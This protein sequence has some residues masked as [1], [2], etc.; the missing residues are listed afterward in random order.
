M[1]K[2]NVKDNPMCHIV[3]LAKVRILQKFPEQREW[4][5]LLDSE[6]F[7]RK[8]IKH[9]NAIIVVIL[10]NCDIKTVRLRR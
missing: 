8:S 7:L 10:G 6:Y 3:L 1:H 5:L 9:G 2:R 4:R